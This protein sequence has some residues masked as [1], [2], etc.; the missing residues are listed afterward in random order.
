MISITP[1]HPLLYRLISLS[2]SSIVSHPH[3]PPTVLTGTSRLVLIVVN[4]GVSSV[5]IFA[6]VGGAVYQA[7]AKREDTATSNFVEFVSI[8][9]RI[10]V[11]VGGAV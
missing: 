4:S 2:C 11:A 3:D 5:R 1:P 6:V 8:S 10:S 7:V 9:V